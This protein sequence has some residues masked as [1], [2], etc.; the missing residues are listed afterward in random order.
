MERNLNMR[1]LVTGATGFIGSHLVEALLNKRFSVS[2]LI[3]DD[4]PISWIDRNRIKIYYGDITKKN[5]LYQAFNS[6]Y[7]FIFHLAG[8]MNT[9]HP[10][11]YYKINFEGT[12]NLLDLCR[13]KSRALKRF[14]YVSSVTA[15]GPCKNLRPKKINCENNPTTH[16]G[17]SKLKTEDYIIKNG[18]QVPF[19]IIRPALVYGPRNKR[20]VFSYF[21]FISIGL[22]PVIGDGYTNVIYVKDLAEILIRSAL[23]DKTKNR[24]YYAGER[25]IYNYSEIA[26]VIKKCM[27]KRVITVRFPRFSIIIIGAL[28]GGVSKILGKPPVFDLRRAVDLKYKYWVYDTTL[29]LEDIEYEPEYSLERGIEETVKWY[30]DRGWIK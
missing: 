11:Q 23:S 2:C 12:K 26:D 10:E 18:F 8:L 15:A 3:K 24:I 25:K 20:T 19:T 14:I 1:A 6:R 4:E 13:E 30:R 27:K 29:L 21:Q 28:I 7:D 22:N 5:S 16:Y 17:K 9:R